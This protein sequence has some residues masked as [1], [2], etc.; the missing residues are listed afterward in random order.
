MGRS[1][2]AVGEEEVRQFSA[3]NKRPKEAARTSLLS[4]FSIAIIDIQTGKLIIKKNEFLMVLETGKSNIKVLAS[5]GG[6]SC[7]ITW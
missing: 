1:Q 6:P 7:F 2:K 5:G 3:G 4:W